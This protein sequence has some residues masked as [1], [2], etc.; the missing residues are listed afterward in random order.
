M[1][2]GDSAS[3]IILNSL[4]FSNTGPSLNRGLKEAQLL[5]ALD[6]MRFICDTK[7]PGMAFNSLFLKKTCLF[8]VC[9]GSLLKILEVQH[10]ISDRLWGISRPEQNMHKKSL[11]MLA[12]TAYFFL[13]LCLQK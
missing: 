12:N 9:D 4:N 5:C 2:I 6:L 7:G 8:L 10:D 1:H 13:L 3:A 11:I